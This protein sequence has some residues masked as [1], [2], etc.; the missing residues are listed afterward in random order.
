MSHTSGEVRD[1][2]GRQQ[3]RSAKSGCA[4]WDSVG[5]QFVTL[6]SRFLLRKLFALPSLE[7]QIVASRQPWPYSA[8]RHRVDLVRSLHIMRAP[9]RPVFYQFSPARA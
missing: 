5:H 4:V 6:G 7:G 8:V 9:E 3:T 1:S 2:G